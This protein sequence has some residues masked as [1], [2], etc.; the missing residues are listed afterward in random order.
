MPFLCCLSGIQAFHPIV[1]LSFYVITTDFSALS[2]SLLSL[3]FPLSTELFLAIFLFILF[4]FGSWRVSFLCLCL[5]QSI[6]SQF[7]RWSCCSS[8]LLL[9]TRRTLSSLAFMIPSIVFANLLRHLLYIYWKVKNS[10]V[11]SI[12]YLKFRKKKP[13]TKISNWHFLDY[14]LFINLY[15]RC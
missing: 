3:W 13:C 5:L 9:T 11:Y 14:I 8:R 4:Y 12:S 1:C 6:S 2:L 7:H 10:P 15:V